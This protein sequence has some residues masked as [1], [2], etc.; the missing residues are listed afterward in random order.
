MPP[1]HPHRTTQTPL[2]I[3]KELKYNLPALVGT[4]SKC[5]IQRGVQPPALMSLGTEGCAQSPPWVPP[6]AQHSTPWCLGS[7]IP[8]LLCP[9]CASS[10]LPGPW[11]GED[12]PCVPLAAVTSLQTEQGWL[13]AGG[14]NA[15]WKKKK[16]VSSWH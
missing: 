5:L 7:T 16:K 11:Q 1:K 3:P 15:V 9:H 13:G 14:L 6:A 4:C 2:R 8:L 10:A 12:V